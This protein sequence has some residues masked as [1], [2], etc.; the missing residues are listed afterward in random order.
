MSLLHIYQFSIFIWMSLALVGSTQSVS[1][2][3]NYLTPDGWGS[4]G[5]IYYCNVQNAVSI[6]SPDT[7]QVDSISGTHQAGYNNDNVVAISI[8]QGQIHYF[9]HGLNKFF[10]NLRGIEILNTGLKE[11]HQ[12]DLKNLPKLIDLHLWSSNLEILEENLFEFNPN[13]EAVSF[14]SNK[15][16]HIDP[17]MFNKLTKLKTLDLRSNTCIDMNAINNPTGVQNIIKTAQAQCKNSDYSSLEQMVK[18]LEIESKTLNSENL[19]EKIENL[20]NEIKNSKFQNFFQENL[21]G[22]KAS[23]IEKTRKEFFDTISAIVK[24]N[25]LEMC[26]ALESKVD[27]VSEKL[28]HISNAIMMINKNYDEQNRR[29]TTLMKA[30]ENAFS[31]GHQVV[32]DS[33]QP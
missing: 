23:L 28:T 15:I 24:N 10:K 7:A 18:N 6:T 12:S 5:A 9:P 33:E 11:L 30:L 3:C 20:E 8:G 22:L 16:S 32:T 21:K 2:Q 19:R 29:F 26:S 13:L 31:A 1:F 25:S 4:L 14:Y 17:N 27:D